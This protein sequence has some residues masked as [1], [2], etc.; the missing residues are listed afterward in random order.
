MRAPAQGGVFNDPGELRPFRSG[1]FIENPD[2]SISTERS[3]TAKLPDGQWIN[4]PSLWMGPG[5]PVDFGDDEDAI[6]EQGLAFEENTG[7]EFKRFKTRRQAI[8]AA[9]ARSS[10]GGAF[11]KEQE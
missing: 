11:S 10:A 6:V 2:G 3:V 4:L 5:G 8:D 9:K 1:E 7:E